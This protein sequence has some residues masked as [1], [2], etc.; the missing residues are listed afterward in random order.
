M[1]R[2]LLLLVGVLCA[3][4]LLV[5]GCGT[6]DTGAQRRALYVDQHPEL[7]DDMVESILNERIAVGMSQEMV[8]VAWG[9]PGRVEPV[10]PVEGADTNFAELWIYGNY[11]VGGTITNLFF[12]A[13]KVLVKYEVVH[14][15]SQS[16]ATGPNASVKDPLTPVADP[17]GGLARKP[18]GG[19]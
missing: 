7:T 8:T 13:D 17:D 19:R 10:E 2:R 5:V 12:D 18:G 9:K 1:C 16:N 4:V 3:G 14:R 11:F 6:V 15:S